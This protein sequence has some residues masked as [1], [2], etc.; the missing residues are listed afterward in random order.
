MQYIDI[1]ENVLI[2]DPLLVAEVV[3]LAKVAPV[4]DLKIERT[5]MATNQITTETRINSS[6]KEFHL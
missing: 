2:T 6:R 4:L 5:G 1:L 3:L